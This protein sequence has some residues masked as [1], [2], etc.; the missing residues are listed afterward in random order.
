MNLT[1]ADFMAAG[2]DIVQAM[3]N[4]GYGQNEIDELVCAFVGLRGMV[5]LA[6]G[7]AN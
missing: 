7:S 6:D 4:L 1:N 5:V 3:K 2:N